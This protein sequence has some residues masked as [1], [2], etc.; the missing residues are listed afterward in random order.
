MRLVLLSL[1]ALVLVAAGAA[2]GAATVAKTEGATS[3]QL[4]GGAGLAS[5]RSRGNVLGRVRRGGIVATANVHV[6]GC[7]SKTQRNNGLVECRGKGITFRTLGDTSWRVRLRGR[8]ISAS[9]IA[10]GC[11]IL[12]ARDTGSTGTFRIGGEEAHPW[13]RQRTSYRLGAGTC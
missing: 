8:G 13:P 12:D 7:A 2:S 6:N 10:R 11:L 5:I 1:F 4:N 9:G 3:V